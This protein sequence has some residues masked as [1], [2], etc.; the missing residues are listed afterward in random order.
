MDMIG[1]EDIGVD[2][3][4]MTIRGLREPATVLRV[5][6]FAEEDRAAIVATL[7]HVERLIG[8]ESAT[9]PSH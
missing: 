8:Q 4:A 3:A 1:H 2:A 5:V 9:E 7:N 6:V